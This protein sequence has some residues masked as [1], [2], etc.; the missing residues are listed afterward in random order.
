MSKL[1]RDPSTDLQQ[2]PVVMECDVDQ[3]AVVQL[4]RAAWDGTRPQA[5]V[6]RGR[7]L[8]RAGTGP[9]SSMDYPS[10]TRSRCG[11][12]RRAA[13]PCRPRPEA[14]RQ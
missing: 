2:R 4:G 7:E 1:G 8:K 5:R 3:W 10:H 11:W 12:V 6:D 9:R 13:T 14:G